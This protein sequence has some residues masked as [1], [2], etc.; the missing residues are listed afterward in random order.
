MTYRTGSLP[1]SRISDSSSFAVR[2]ALE[3]YAPASPRSLVITRIAARRGSARSVSSGWSLV[4]LEASAD[5][6]RVSSLV[7][8]SAACTRCCALAM[9]EVATSSIAL[10]ICLVWLTARIRR[11]RMRRVP[12]I[13][14]ALGG[15]GRSRL[16]VA[17]DLLLADLAGLHRLDLRL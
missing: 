8:G 2:R 16:P 13:A 15:R 7:Y 6:A 14:S 12:A 1:S 5:S 3:L 10:V 4:E 17:G 9:R 11:R